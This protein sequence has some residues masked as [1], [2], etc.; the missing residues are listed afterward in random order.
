VRA[1]D[2]F[3]VVVVVQLVLS[4]KHYVLDY[5]STEVWVILEVTFFK[6]LNSGFFFFFWHIVMLKLIKLPFSVEKIRFME[7][8]R[9]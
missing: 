3:V 8:I 7:K 4:N 5:V 1:A 6:K 2:I 9:E